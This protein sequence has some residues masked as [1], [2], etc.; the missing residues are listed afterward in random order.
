MKQVRGNYTAEQPDKQLARS[1]KPLEVD[2]MAEA[3]RQEHKR[4]AQ[5]ADGTIAVARRPPPLFKSA[6][7]DVVRSNKPHDVDEIEV[8]G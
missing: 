7:E 3:K 1:S 8:K 4:G 2:A 5:L 6:S